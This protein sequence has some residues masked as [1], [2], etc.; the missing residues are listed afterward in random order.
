MLDEM[1]RGSQNMQQEMSFYPL[2]DHSKVSTM[3]QIGQLKTSALAH[4]SSRREAGGLGLTWQSPQTPPG[5]G[6]VLH[7]DQLES[8]RNGQND[9]NF[10]GGAQQDPGQPR[11]ASG[12]LNA[13]K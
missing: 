9:L 2:E 12:Y 10:E 3:E 7:Q 5:Q 13:G 11:E 8:R 1:R 6:Q 4:Q